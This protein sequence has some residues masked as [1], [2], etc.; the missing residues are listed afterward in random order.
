MTVLAGVQFL[1]FDRTCCGLVGVQ[2]QGV[3]QQRVQDRVHRGG[4]RGGGGT[5]DSGL[6]SE[7]LIEDFVKLPRQSSS[8]IIARKLSAISFAFTARIN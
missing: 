8:I 4:D 1:S 2:G 3:L 5:H 7:S 6:C